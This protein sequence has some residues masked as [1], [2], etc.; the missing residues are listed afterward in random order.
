MTHALHLPELGTRDELGH[1]PPRCRR[2]EGILRSV[3]DQCGSGHTRQRLGPTPRG[4]DGCELSAEATRIRVPCIGLSTYLQVRRRVRGVRRAGEHI[5]DPYNSL[6]CR[7]R[8]TRRSTLEHRL[9]GIGPAHQEATLTG[10]GHDGDKPRDTLRIVNGHG[11][12]D[13]PTHGGAHHHGPLV[14]ERIQEPHRIR[15]HILQPVWGLDRKTHG[16]PRSHLGHRGRALTIHVGG[17]SHVPIVHA[18]DREALLDQ[19]LPEIFPPVDELAPDP[20]DEEQR[21][22]PT[23]LVVADGDPVGLDDRHGHSLSRTTPNL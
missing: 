4:Q 13:H 11:L 7:L 15:R 6:T 12:G 18:D 5:H 16:P 23:D 20:H 21:R 8:R 19:H 10:V 14:A 2:D 9:D 22:A 1:T 17:Q 3:D